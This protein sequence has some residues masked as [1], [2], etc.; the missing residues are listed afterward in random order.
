M[1]IKDR[2][3]FKS[4]LSI[5]LIISLLFSVTSC[6]RKVKKIDSELFITTLEN[7]FDIDEATDGG[8]GDSY[9]TVNH[10]MGIYQTRIVAYIDKAKTNAIYINYYIY[11][12]LDEAEAHFTSLY[13]YYYEE[14]NE[15]CCGTYATG[16]SGYFVRANEKVFTASYYYEDMVIEIHV[17]SEDQ[18]ELT[19][20][21]IEALELPLE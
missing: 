14:D 1:D 9:Y 15:E 16:K 3:I 6:K 4:T 10:H 7:Q 2:R 11:Y 5:L 12:E 20:T 8:I 13:N 17:N 21:F 19:K 18:I